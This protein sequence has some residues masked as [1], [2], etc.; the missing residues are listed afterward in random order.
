LFLLDAHFYLCALVPMVANACF[1]FHRI[2]KH[3]DILFIYGLFNDADSI[4][5]YATSNYGMNNE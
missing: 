4:S 5:D 1:Q 2:L 3:L